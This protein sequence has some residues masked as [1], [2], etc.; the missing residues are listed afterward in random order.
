MFMM[1]LQT[2]VILTGRMSLD[3][4]CLAHKL[5]VCMM[6]VPGIDNNVETHSVISLDTHPSPMSHEFEKWQ[7]MT[8]ASKQL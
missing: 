7:R 2:C 1:A 5:F 6:A 8:N 4:K 3:V